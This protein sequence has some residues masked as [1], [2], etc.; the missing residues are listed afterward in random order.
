M[1]NHRKK[2]IYGV[3]FMDPYTIQIH[4]E[5]VNKNPDELEKS[6]FQVLQQST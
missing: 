4:Q 2:G 5:I 3:G 6:N 1:M